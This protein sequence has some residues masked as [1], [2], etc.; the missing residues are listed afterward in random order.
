[1]RSS[2]LTFTTMSL[3]CLSS[4]GFSCLTTADSS[5]ASRPDSLT[6]KLITITCGP[7]AVQ[8]TGLS[9]PQ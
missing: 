3:R 9:Q 1:V 8:A 6:A 4:S 7:S 2:W 5:C